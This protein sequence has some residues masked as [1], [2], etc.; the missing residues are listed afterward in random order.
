MK[1]P[2][3]IGRRL[4]LASGMIFLLL[5]VSMA[6]S[7]IGL[8]HIDHSHQQAMNWTAQARNF[9]TFLRGINELIV[10]ERSK[11]SLDLTRDAI[12]RLDQ[13]FGQLAAQANTE[14]RPAVDQLAARWA[15]MKKQVDT[16]INIKN[17]SATNDEAMIAVGK[18]ITNTGEVLQQVEQNAV[19]ATEHS[20]VASTT[21]NTV[22]IGVSL[23]QLILVGTIFLALHRGIFR[24]LGGD[25]AYATSI[26]QFIAQGRLRQTIAAA[27]DH[28]LLGA[29][30][31]M[32]GK[33]SSHFQVIDGSARSLQESAGQI[34]GISGEIAKLSLS[35]Q[36]RS[37]TVVAALATVREV[38]L[39]V[40]NLSAEASLR[41]D[42]SAT[43]AKGGLVRIRSN[44]VEMDAVSN[45]VNVTS[46]YL[47]ELAESAK[48]IHSILDT[49]GG[50]AEQTNLLALNAAI[51]AARAGEVGK[52]F[53]VVADEV[54]KLAE[55]TSTSTREINQIVTDVGKQVEQATLSMEKVVV[56][57][58]D[59]Q[60][61]AISAANTFEAVCAVA[62]D[63]VAATANIGAVS[64]RQ[65]AVVAD[66]HQHMQALH[67][68]LLDN[69]EK[70]GANARIGG[71][72]A[73]TSRDLNQILSTFD[74]ER[75]VRA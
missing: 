12:T 11:S 47:R 74:F 58:H 37:H 53:A 55:R 13:V 43:E 21:L 32:A 6:A 66:L 46:N 22:I 52:G 31:L 39:E 72:L 25:P 73:A 34:V 26:V 38:S 33:L 41:A 17:L 65:V 19:Q 64:H 71:A 62:H 16:F 70:I 57:V 15:D 7:W 69:A 48:R 67:T 3:T 61:S 27:N 60:Q 50:I 51:E 4:L 49:I 56:K 36:Q 30:K 28:S 24:L 8:R 2:I 10:T 18:L 54:R 29:M 75:A 63:T 5:L 20:K 45:D 59:S 68:A 14:Q 40:Q 23:V 1:Q 35:E 9:Q 44:I 42:A